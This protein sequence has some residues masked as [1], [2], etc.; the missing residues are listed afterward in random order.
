MASIPPRLKGAFKMRPI[1]ADKHSVGT[2]A[3]VGGSCRYA[4]APVMAGL[5]ARSAGAGLVTIVAPNV[6]R[7]AMAAL[8]PEAT[9]M[10]LTPTSEP[11]R[12]DVV[13]LGMGLGVDAAAELVVS[14]ILA[15]PAGRIVVDADALSVLAALRARSAWLGPAESQELILTPHEGEA[16][17]LLGC[18]RAEIS[19]N[20][21]P[22]AKRIAAMY[23][24]TVVLKGANTL[25]VSRD[26]S[27]TYKNKTGNPFMA[28]GGMGDLL[29][30]IIGARWAY[31]KDDPF[32]AAASSVWLHALASDRIVAAMKDPT[33]VNTA[34]EVGALRTCLDGRRGKI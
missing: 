31:L 13:I 22:S 3:V 10:R 21:L 11:P 16:A 14:R 17:R 28:L 7:L 29:A 26:G 32:M 1:D 25:V 24:A 23:G 12:S 9:F 33:I 2:V 4:N 15:G 20:R 8:L 30:G 18:E 19:A 27:A 6:S 5:G 34:A